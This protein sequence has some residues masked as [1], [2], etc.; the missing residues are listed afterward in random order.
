MPTRLKQLEELL[1]SEPNDP[2][3]RYGVAM[4]HKKA[5]RLDEALH[6]FAR[7]L[8]A[9]ATYCYAW[10]QQGQVL[11]ARGDLEAARDVYERGIAAA[12]KCNDQHAAG[13][14]QAALDALEA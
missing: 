13:E 2:F 9:D 14:M 5:G 8:E 4:E 7:T 6:W 1:R 12:R 11:A 10:Y 3:L